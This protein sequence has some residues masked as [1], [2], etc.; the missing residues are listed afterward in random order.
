MVPGGLRLGAPAL[1]SRGFKELEFEKIADIID[2]AIDIAKEVQ[3]KTKKLKEFKEFLDTDEETVKKLN[4][5][6]RRVNEFAAMYPMPGHDN[7]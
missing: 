5:M 4:D 2:E 3:G 1:T 6:K 7:Y